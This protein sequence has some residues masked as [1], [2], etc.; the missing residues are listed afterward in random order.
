MTKME[1]A[2]AMARLVRQRLEEINEM[3]KQ[4]AAAGISISYQAE[5]APMTK[6]PQ[7]PR[8]ELRAQITIEL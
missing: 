1:D 7:V 2:V 5:E 4:A 6:G 3:G 8:Y